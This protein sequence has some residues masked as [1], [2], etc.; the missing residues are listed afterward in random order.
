M[1]SSESNSPLAESQPKVKVYFRRWLILS[2]FCLVSFISAFN[3][4]EHNIIQ[5]VT[6]AFYTP[7]LPENNTDKQT[8]VNWLSMVYSL[9]YIPFVFPAMFFLDRKGLKLSLLLGIF[10]VLHYGI[11]MQFICFLHIVSR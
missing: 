3:Y 2:T 10:T 5:D 6:V 7:S 9:L 8:A 11:G 1:V 4:I